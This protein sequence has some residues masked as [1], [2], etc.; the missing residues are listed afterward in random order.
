M[1]DR[2]SEAGNSISI[3]A[4]TRGATGIGP[5]GRIAL[6]VISI[7]APT[8]GATYKALEALPCSGIFQFTP[9]RE[10]RPETLPAPIG[11]G[12]GFQFTPLREGRRRTA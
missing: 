5:D 4:P 1:D 3:H 10:G 6:Y 7:H 11:N 9:L 8:R 2:G 12:I